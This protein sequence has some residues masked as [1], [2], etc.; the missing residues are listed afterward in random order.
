MVNSIRQYFPTYF[1]GFKPAVVVF[2]TTD[3]LLRIPFVSKFRDGTDFSRFSISDGILMAE[4]NGGKT[5]WVVGAI[6]VP[7]EIALPLWGPVYDKPLA[8]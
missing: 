4:Y 5:W 8:I 2:E 3:E 1:D 7:S 6:A